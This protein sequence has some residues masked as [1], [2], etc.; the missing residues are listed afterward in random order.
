MEDSELNRRKGDKD[1]WVFDGKTFME[2]QQIRESVW[3]LHSNV[4]KL[5]GNRSFSH[6]LL[7]AWSRPQTPTECKMTFSLN[8]LFC[9][10]PAPLCNVA[11]TQPECVYVCFELLAKMN[12]GNGFLS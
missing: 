1:T 4:Q 3:V 5:C 9:V 12:E 6:G 10:M 8:K 11:K 7:Y 2:V